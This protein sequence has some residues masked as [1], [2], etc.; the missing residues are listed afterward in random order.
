MKHSLQTIMYNSGTVVKRETVNPISMMSNTT[1]FRNNKNYLL[2]NLNR[3]FQNKYNFPKDSGFQILN[4]GKI[5]KQIPKEPKITVKIQTCVKSITIASSL[6]SMFTSMG[7]HSVLLGNETIRNEIRNNKEGNYDIYFFLYVNEIRLL[8]RKSVYFIYNLEQTLYFSDF[9]RMSKWYKTKEK[10]DFNEMAFN[11]CKT[12]FDYSTTNIENY[13]LGLRGKVEY[14]PFPLI[15]NIGF[16]HVDWREKSIDILFFG[17]E[18]DRRK[19]IINFLIQQGFKVEV[20]NHIGGDKLYEKIRRA[21]VVLNIHSEKNSILEIA[22]LHDCFR[23]YYVPVVSE[24]PTERDR[25]LVEKYKDLVTFVPVVEDDL[26]NVDLLVKALNEKVNAEIN[27]Q[28]VNKTLL[29]LNE[30]ITKKY[31]VFKPL[32]YPYLFHKIVVGEK[33]LN[34]KI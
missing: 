7:I 31:E 30:E 6:Q 9:P 4:R 13:P 8:P 12:I 14:L 20:F 11:N 18:I 19:N 16:K 24:M 28:Q 32:K 33:G 5:F 15:D 3:S 29:K 22:R 23:R 25:Y 2:S 27:Y 34:D 17:H 10:Q 26:S 1:R 21:K